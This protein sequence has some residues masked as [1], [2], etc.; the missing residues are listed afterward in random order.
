MITNLLLA[1]YQSVMDWTADM[2]ESIALALLVLGSAVPG[3]VLL[4]LVFG[5]RRRSPLSHPSLVQSLAAAGLP[6]T[7]IARR[8]GLSQDAVALLLRSTAASTVR[9]LPHPPSSGTVRKST[10][11]LLPKFLSKS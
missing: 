2:P 8:T 11:L 9:N 6:P 1:W 10:G 3:A 7:E 5:K 4:N